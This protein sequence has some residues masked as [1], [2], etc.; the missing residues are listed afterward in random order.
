MLSRGGDGGT[1][2]AIWSKNVP[3]PFRCRESVPVITPLIT[4]ALIALL[5]E[6]EKTY[7]VDPARVYLTGHSMERYSCEGE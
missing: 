5:D 7:A 1:E 6:V 2:H 4:E 3:P